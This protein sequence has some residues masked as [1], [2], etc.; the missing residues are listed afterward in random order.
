MSDRRLRELERRWKESQSVEDEGNYL[1]ER[2]R[3]GDLTEQQLALAAHWGHEGASRAL[4]R[5]WK[6]TDLWRLLSSP[7]TR[8]SWFDDV[9]RL[10][11]TARA[12]ELVCNLGRVVASRWPEGSEDHATLA[13]QL[14]NM[15]AWVSCPCDEHFVA[16]LGRG[17]LGR[18]HPAINAIGAVMYAVSSR[19]SPMCEGQSVGDLTERA[20]DRCSGL[21]GESPEGVL[22]EALGVATSRLLVALRAQ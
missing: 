14:T 17:T 10:Y 20:L 1:R 19:T 5:A 21:L 11:G 22:R 7:E 3:V 15:E 16:F 9:E 2:V 13:D 18:V 12:I 4:G 6:P 8:R